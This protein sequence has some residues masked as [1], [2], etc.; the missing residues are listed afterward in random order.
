MDKAERWN[1]DAYKEK[2]AIEVE[3]SSCVQVFKDAF[4]FLIGQ[5]MSQIEVGVVIVRKHLEAEG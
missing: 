2:V 5:A 4:K 1:Y 3:L